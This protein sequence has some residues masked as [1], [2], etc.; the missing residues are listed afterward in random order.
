LSLRC[1][2][3]ALVLQWPLGW[4]SDIIDRRLVIIGSGILSTAATGVAA[5]TVPDGTSQL[6]FAFTFMYGGTMIPLYALSVAHV[7]DNIDSQELVAAASGLVMVYGVGASIGPF[8]ASLVVSRVGPGGLFPAACRGR[9]D[10]A[11]VRRRTK[12]KSCRIANARASR[13]PE[14]RSA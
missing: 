4:L 6:L 7:N 2:L 14:S 5:I 8:A 1:I 13:R 12:D 3:G 10:Q 11:R 9:G